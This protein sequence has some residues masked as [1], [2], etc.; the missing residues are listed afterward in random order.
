MA[1]RRRGG[2]PAAAARDLAADLEQPAL[3]S[4]QLLVRSVG[5]RIGHTLILR[6]LDDLPAEI[7]GISM[8]VSSRPDEKTFVIFYDSRVPAWSQELIILHE[9]G[10]HVLGHHHAPV[11]DPDPGGGKDAAVR[12]P[13]RPAGPPT[14]A[15]GLG[16]TLFIDQREVDAEQF[17]TYL[18]DRLARLR[19]FTGRPQ[20]R[21]LRRGMA[22]PSSWDHP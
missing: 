15:C 12:D 20:V 10:H 6:P 16:R 13:P 11:I 5:E 8:P 9:L 4:T 14:R 2:R 19:Q 18:A 1:S 22:A 17:A 21:E 3:F 7:S